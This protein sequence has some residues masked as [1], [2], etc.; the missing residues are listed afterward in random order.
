MR[1]GKEHARQA[2][3][4]V[5][6]GG[7]RASTS[8]PVASTSGPSNSGIIPPEQNI[9]NKGVTL[10]STTQPTDPDA[11]SGVSG[12]SMSQTESGVFHEVLVDCNSL[13]EAYHKGEILKATVY[14]EIQSKLAKALSDDRGRSDATFGSF[15]VTIKSHDSEVAAAA[16]KGKAFNPLQHSPS[17]GGLYTPPRIPCGVRAESTRNMWGSVKY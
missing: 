2:Q 5:S 17:S 13:V 10:P 14:I 12:G 7:P 8:G 6:E 15:I 11:Q 16:S 9:G 1:S 3:P 4:T